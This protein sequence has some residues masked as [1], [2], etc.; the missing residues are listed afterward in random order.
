[1]S[2]MACASIL[3]EGL[4]R[5]AHGNRAT[6]SL[7]KLRAALDRVLPS[8]RI[9]QLCGVDACSGGLPKFLHLLSPSLV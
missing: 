5:W 1:M 7:P 2:L 9:R 8:N 3:G 4:L 6:A